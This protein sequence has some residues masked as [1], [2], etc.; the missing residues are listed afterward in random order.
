MRTLH[1]ATERESPRV[2]CNF[3]AGGGQG[4][5]VR[6]SNTRV[7]ETGDAGRYCSHRLSPCMVP[8]SV[9]VQHTAEIDAN[10]KRH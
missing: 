3:D 9:W 2:C 10:R 8:T 5:T 1:E 4:P 6:P 7:D